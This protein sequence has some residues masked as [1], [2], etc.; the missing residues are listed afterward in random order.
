MKFM[1][2]QTLDNPFD[3]VWRGLAAEISVVVQKTEHG[4]G[5]VKGAARL[6]QTLVNVWFWFH[7][8]STM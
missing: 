6:P 1:S 5:L 7:R 8:L 2:V 3:L 4:N